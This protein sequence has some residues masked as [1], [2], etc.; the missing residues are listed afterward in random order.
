MDCLQTFRVS[1]V[2]PR[3][4]KITDQI[5]DSD[6]RE[7]V[8]ELLEK[9]QISIG[10]KIYSG[11]QFET[12]PAGLFKHHSYPGG[13]LDHTIATAEIAL[14]LCEI[15]EGVYYGKVDRDL[16]LSGIILHDVFKTLAY[17]CEDSGRYINSDLG[18]RLDH[19]SLITSELIRRN[20]PINLVHI[21]CAHHGG[22]VGPTWPRTVEALICHLADQTDSQLNGEVLRAARH[23]V[24]RA[25]GEE[26]PLISS[27]EAFYV[28]NQ[29]TLHGL[30]GVQTAFSRIM[31]DRAH[32]GS[33][34]A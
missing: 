8:K 12:A 27:K 29:K 7:K 3:L 14:S 5:E 23:L 22:S 17:R 18:E 33:E 10:G 13:L 30:E 32:S 28:V 15:I 9:P 31:K 16:V 26:I 25:T 34:T 11:F 21:V 24:R 20:F 19:L 6:L 2:N 1:V 4:S